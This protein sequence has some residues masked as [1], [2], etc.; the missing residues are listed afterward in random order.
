MTYF[1]TKMFQIEQ[2][3]LNVKD[4]MAPLCYFLPT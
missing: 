1:E 4:L 2:D 3:P